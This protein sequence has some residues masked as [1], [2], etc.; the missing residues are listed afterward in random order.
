MTTAK[1]SAVSHAKTSIPTQANFGAALSVPK[2][3][4]ETQLRTSSELLN[5]ASQ[6]MHAQAEFLGRFMQCAT[7]DEAAKVQGQYFEGMIAD[8]G[9]EI[10]HLAELAQE[11]TMM[12]TDAAREATTE[13][14][15]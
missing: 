15:H 8:Y 1:N 6:R 13:T 7:L 2:K 5:F 12:A 4:V 3:L 14:S 11:A 10:K 9:R